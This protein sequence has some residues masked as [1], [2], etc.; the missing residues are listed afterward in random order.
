MALVGVLLVAITLGLATA[1]PAQA[2]TRRV[3]EVTLSEFKIEPSQITFNEG[4][5]VVIRLR[6]A[7]PRFPHT[8]ASR[9]LVNIPL[10][11]RGDA[12]QGVDEDR[13]WVHVDVGKSGEFEFVAQGRGSAAFICSLFTHAPAGMVGAF[14]IKPS[15][16]Q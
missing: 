10:T 15:G 5:T 14:F 3:I 13:K 8:L 11:V 16:S 7:G 6:N 4:D 9:Y 2:P 12:R 1:G